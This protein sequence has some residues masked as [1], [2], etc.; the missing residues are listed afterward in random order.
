MK[1]LL[2]KPVA[3]C[4]ET[5][6]GYLEQVNQS[7]W[8]TNFG[9]LHQKLT[10][11]LE[12]YLGVD[13]L[14][15]VSNGTLALHVAYRALDVKRSICTPFSYVATAGSL[16]WEKI[17]TSFVDIDPNSLNLCPILVGKMLEE[18]PDIDSIVATHVYGN[19]CRV[20][21]FDNISVKHSVKVIY[22]G[23]HAFGVKYCGKSLLSYGDAATL[24][25][26]ATKVFHTVEGGAV[27]FKDKSRY[28]RA[29]QLINF[30]LDSSGIPKE[31]GINAKL[32]EYQAAVGL[33]LL[34]SIDDILEHRSSL[35]DTYTNILESYV[36]LPS[37]NTNTSF[38][39][40]SYF[41]IILESQEEK[42]RIKVLL[43]KLGIP[44]REYFSPSLDIV[45]NPLNSCLI[46]QSVASRVLCL[47]LHYYLSVKEVSYI[48][49]IIKRGRS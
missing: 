25:F 7:G 19:P 47:P 41:P 11:R 37:W 9:P 43:Q 21:L 2:N 17:P 13:N 44:S 22:D 5:L 42:S 27:I 16:A 1:I 48:A 45:F 24:S 18:A 32:N 26:H 46:S 15:L 8:Y 12:E 20:E 10:H 39:N 14:L 49:N 6:G 23:A 35:F 36:A 4:L 40:G 38:K 34:D 31:A 28:E 29:K 30:G 3:P 33:T